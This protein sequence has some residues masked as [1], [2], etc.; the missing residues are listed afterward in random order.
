MYTWLKIW[1]KV[2]PL[3]GVALITALFA[4][5]RYFMMAVPNWV[6]LPLIY[7]LIVIRLLLTDSW[8]GILLAG[9]CAACVMLVPC[10]GDHVRTRRFLTRPAVAVMVMLLLSGWAIE[11][12]DVWEK[13]RYQRKLDTVYAQIHDFVEVADAALAYNTSSQHFGNR[14]REEFPELRLE[15]MHSDGVH[16]YYSDYVLIDYDTKRIGIVFNHPDISFFTYQL[17]P[18]DT[19]P[20]HGIQGGASLCAPGATFYSYWAQGDMPQYTDGFA[21]VM[22]DG[23]IYVITGL[24]S[25]ENLFLGLDSVITPIEDFLEKK[26][27]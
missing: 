25:Q 19:Y 16:Y 17:K 12:N 26:Y 22:E 18:A 23:G 8:A 21:L 27:D 10:Y 3:L 5:F 1:Y 13:Q 20:K 9:I 2:K 4:C 14:F 24:C 15:T 7:P 11:R 6:H